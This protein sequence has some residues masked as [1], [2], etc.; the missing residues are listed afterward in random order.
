MGDCDDRFERPLATT[1]A[2]ASPVGIFAML[3]LLIPNVGG[4]PPPTPGRRPARQATIALPSVATACRLRIPLGIRVGCTI[5]TVDSDFHQGRYQSPRNYASERAQLLDVLA[6]MIGLMT[7]PAAR[8][9]SLFRREVQKTTLSD[10]R[11]HI[12]GQDCGFFNGTEC[13]D[14]PKIRPKPAVLDKIGG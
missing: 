7:A 1:P 14:I 11:Q 2:L 8:M 3:A 9:M 13:I 10:D 12:R 4:L 5:A 6:L